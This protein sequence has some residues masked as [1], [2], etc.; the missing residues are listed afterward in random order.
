MREIKFRGQRADNKEWIYG[1][2][3]YTVYNKAYQKAYNLIQEDGHYIY[4]AHIDSN[5]K[6]V[7]I[8]TVGQ[9][10]GLKDKNGVEIYEGDILGI[11]EQKKENWS[12]D[13]YFKEGAFFITPNVAESLLNNYRAGRSIVIGNINSN[14]ELLK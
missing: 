6:E 11:P 8:E 4:P 13:V 14:P 7:L 3:Q 9:F 10:T 5:P 12:G 2:Y 1:F